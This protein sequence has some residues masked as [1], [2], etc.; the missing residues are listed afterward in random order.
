MEETLVSALTYQDDL[1]ELSDHNGK[2]IFIISIKKFHWNRDCPWNS[3]VEGNM[4]DRKFHH[5]LSYKQRLRTF[6]FNFT[7]NFLCYLFQF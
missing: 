4:W 5:Q 7:I 3:F 6:M 1:D 2:V